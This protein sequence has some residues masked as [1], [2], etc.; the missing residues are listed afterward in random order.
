M[1]NAYGIKNC[2]LIAKQNRKIHRRLT[3]LRCQNINHLY[4]STKTLR[5]LYQIDEIVA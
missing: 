1:V 2:L 5:Y 4:K 3:E